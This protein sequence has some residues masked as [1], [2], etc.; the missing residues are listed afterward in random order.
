MTE[1]LTPSVSD[2]SVPSI[3][4]RDICKTFV[5][6]NTAIGSAKTLFLWRKKRTR[7]EVEVLRGVS[8]DVMPGE[9]VAIV[10]RNGAGKSTLLSLISKIYRPT[11]GTVTIRGRLAPL[12]ELGAG[13]HPDLSGAENLRFN[14]AV[15]GLT[16]QEV[17]ERFQSI[18][19]FSEL[20]QHINAPL[21]T[22]SSGMIARLGFSVA[23][24]VDADILVVDEVL[25]VG[26]FEFK[27]KCL[28]HLT[29][30]KRKGGAILLVSH[31]TETVMKFAERA[32]WIQRGLV[33]MT[34][35]PAEVLP[36]FKAKS[37]SDLNR[38]MHE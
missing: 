16:K 29:E 15:L 14:S 22:Y 36:E 37:E 7:V 10:G 18:V 13:F 17:E 28:K 30:F 34:G 5:L 21:R 11:S 26:D 12:L 23:I 1:P 31:D 2:L 8:F 32:I 4:V 33:Q 38:Q 25:S 24:H 6:S 19:E 20:G 3:E 27:E 35:T 9:C